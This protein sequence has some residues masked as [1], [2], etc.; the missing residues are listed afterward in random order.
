MF[1]HWIPEPEPLHEYRREKK[2]KPFVLAHPDFDIQNDMV[3][4]DG[5]LQALIDWDGICAVPRSLGNERYPG[6]LTRDWDPAMYSCAEE[7][8]REGFE[9]EGVW[10][11]S[12][13][14]L[15]FYRA[16]HDGFMRSCLLS[17]QDACD[18]G[19]HQGLKKL[20]E[21][22]KLTRNSLV[23]ENLYIAATDPLCTGSIMDKVFDTIA[24]IVGKGIQE[25]SST[26]SATE[27]PDD[28]N[29]YDVACEVVEGQLGERRLS[30][31]RTGF[32]VLMR[33]EMQ[34]QELKSSQ[35]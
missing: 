1:I 22:I 17:R 32:D 34:F 23:A 24:E 29:L 16:L 13:E 35:S 19:E 3:S 2:K 25:P 7:M 12:A 8:E 5:G 9:P 30:L 26:S 27:E 6:W 28:F 33:G 14:T 21:G 15:A 31:L 11:D 20:D 10:E 18:P 4:E